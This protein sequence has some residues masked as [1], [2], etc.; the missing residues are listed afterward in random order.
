MTLVFLGFFVHSL[1]LDIAFV[2]TLKNLCPYLGV[3]TIAF[4]VII[5]MAGFLNLPVS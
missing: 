4:Y 1:W 3:H 2:S 5:G